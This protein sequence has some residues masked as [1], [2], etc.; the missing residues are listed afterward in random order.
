MTRIDSLSVLLTTT[1]QMEL[2]ERFDGVIANLQKSTLSGRLKNKDLSGDPTTGTVIARRFTNSETKAYGTARAG[3]AGEKL[4]GAEVTVA[5]DVDR[6]LINEVEEKD[7]RLI[8]TDNLIN[9]KISQNEKS[10][11]RELERAFFK[12]AA[13]A[14][15]AATLTATKINEKIEELIQIIEKTKNDFVDGVDRTLIDIVCDTKTYGDM[16]NFLDTIQ[17]SNVDSSAEAF[18]YFHGV[19]IHSSVYLPDKTNVIAMVE[20][21]VAQPVMMT[22]DVAG[23]FEASNAYHFGTFVSYGTKAV[24]PDLIFKIVTA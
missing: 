12:A 15:T 4:K 8:G 18:N 22:Q 13:D 6:E 14:G 11:E 24:T 5:L 1:G 23:K 9:K 2:A 7:T 19:R 20:E 21:S 3:K 17:N 10:I 16:R